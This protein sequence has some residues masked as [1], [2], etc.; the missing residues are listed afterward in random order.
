MGRLTGKTAF[1]T[2][3]GQGIAVAVTDA[4]PVGAPRTRR[5]GSHPFEADRSSPAPDGPMG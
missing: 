2:A 1:V 5:A 3:A 4:P